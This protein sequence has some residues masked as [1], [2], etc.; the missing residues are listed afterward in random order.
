MKGIKDTD[1]IAPE[2]PV[3]ESEEKDDVNEEL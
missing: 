2:E 1:E 3:V